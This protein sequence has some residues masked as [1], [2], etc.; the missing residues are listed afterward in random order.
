MKVTPETIQYLEKLAYL[1]LDDRQRESLSGDLNK[2]LRFAEQLSSLPLGETTPMTHAASL[3]NVLRPDEVKT[4][5]PRERALENAP[6]QDG[7]YYLVPKVL[8]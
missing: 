3:E 7:Q 4:S 1:Q 5:L 6:R 2:I 8:D